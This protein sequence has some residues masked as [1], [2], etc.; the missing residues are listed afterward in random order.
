MERNIKIAYLLTV[1]K[2]A[3]FWLGVWIFFYLK[4]TNYTGIGIIETVL[5]TSVTLFEIPTGAIA[6]LFGKRNTLII[7]FFFLTIGNICL[8]FSL[9]INMLIMSVFISAVGMSLYSGTLEALVY[10][11]LKQLKSEDQYGHV[12]ANI[13][14]I[15]WLTPSICGAMGGFIYLISNR[16]PFILTGL[17]CMFGSAISFILSEPKIDTEKFSFL[18][19]IKQNQN[20]FTQLFTNKDIRKQTLLLLSIGVIVTICDEML[21]SFL[22]VEFGFKSQFNGIFWGVVFAVT[23]L[24]TQLTPLIYSKLGKTKALVLSGGIIGISMIVSPF[25]GLIIGGVSL[26]LRS[27][28]FS[29]FVGLTSIV[30]NEHTESKYRVTTIS[31]FNMIKNIPYVMSAFFFGRL[32][33]LIS[34]KTSTFYL[35]LILLILIVLQGLQ[36]IKDRVKLNNL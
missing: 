15:A 6:D 33:D 27:V 1:C 34:A 12:I 35:G 19:F 36:K 5:F 31:T 14:T 2:N 10:D 16:S 32:S 7:A 26:F 13:N 25:G 28:F 3:W 11:S 22:S 18:N 29:I 30:I 17:F 4:Y 23:S 9:N 20:G 8:G 21:N 24:L